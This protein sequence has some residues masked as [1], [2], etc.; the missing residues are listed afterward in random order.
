MSVITPT[1]P[2]AIHA[3]IHKDSDASLTLETPSGKPQSVPLEQLVSRRTGRNKR[4]ARKREK[5]E[6][7]MG[8]RIV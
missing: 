8:V 2:A 5:K 6:R 7:D 4:S 1:T 3:P